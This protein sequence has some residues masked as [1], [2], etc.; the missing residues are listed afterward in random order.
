MTNR[1]SGFTPLEY[2]NMVYQVDY[3]ANNSFMT[4][5][6]NFLLRRQNSLT[7]FTLLEILVVII[8]VGILAAVAIPM[9]SNSVETNKGKA[10]QNNIRT[11]L[12]AWRIYNLD[13]NPD[14]DMNRVF[15]NVA[16]INA[17]LG[18]NIDEKNFGVSGPNNSNGFY[19]DLYI[20][21]DRTR[22]GTDYMRIYTYR[23]AGQ[24]NQTYIQCYYYYNTGTYTWSKSWPLTIDP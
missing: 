7:G 20:N 6:Y 5:I 8:I 10:C 16:Q 13:H 18:I 15:T 17:D 21:P 11:I 12:T 4:G 22:P 2:T 23:K 1:Q 24:Y 9:Y 14:Y 19:T 3:K